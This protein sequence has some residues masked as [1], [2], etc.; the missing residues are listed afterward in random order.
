MD[1][2]LSKACGACFYLFPPSILFLIYDNFDSPGK[3]SESNSK[4]KKGKKKKNIYSEDHLN[5]LK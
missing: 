1:L 5:L 4:I 3:D 2:N